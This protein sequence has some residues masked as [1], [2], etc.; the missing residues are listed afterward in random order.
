LDTLGKLQV[1]RQKAA[2][3]SAP[4]L[5]ELGIASNKK[6]I[7]ELHAAYEIEINRIIDE[8]TMHEGVMNRV[9]G[10]HIPETKPVAL[11]RQAGYAF[12]N[13]YFEPLLAR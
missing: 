7:R 3:I 2:S 11:L 1:K 5:R 9:L 13:N 10:R 12:Y 6:A 8:M 4:G